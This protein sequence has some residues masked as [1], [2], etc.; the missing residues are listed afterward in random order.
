MVRFSLGED[1]SDDDAAVIAKAPP[2][3]FLKNKPESPPI[4]RQPPPCR[5]RQCA[6]ELQLL[7]D[8]EAQKRSEKKL[9]P[10]RA[11]IQ[12]LGDAGD[13]PPPERAFQ[14]LA[15]ADKAALEVKERQDADIRR[16]ME[17]ARREAALRHA[18]SKKRC[19]AIEN[20]RSRRKEAEAAAKRQDEARQVLASPGAWDDLESLEALDGLREEDLSTIKRAK[21]CVAAIL[22][23]LSSAR[24]ATTEE[25]F[26]E[27][28]RGLTE[29]LALLKEK[30][31]G[32]LTETSAAGL[33]LIHI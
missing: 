20:E 5:L 15:L 18:A 6:L 4:V 27:A 3:R 26:T 33:S 10:F 22:K 28:R 32:L 17:Q 30:R 19:E 23:H 14:A 25:A 7:R 8:R 2:T 16:D 21:A 9:A 24:K 13:C 29:Q 11:R 1:S 12:A 31:C